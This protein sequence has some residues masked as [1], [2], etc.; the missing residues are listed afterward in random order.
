[1]YPLV[2]QQFSIEN[3]HIDIVD[4]PIQHGGSFP[5]V[6]CMFTRPGTSTPGGDVPESR[7]CACDQGQPLVV[8]CGDP[9]GTRI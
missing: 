5:S 4:F 7:E 3:D 2:I 9:G 6:N 1:M 8:V